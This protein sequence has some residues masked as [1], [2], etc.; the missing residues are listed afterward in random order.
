[1]S[2]I[3]FSFGSWRELRYNLG[4]AS[5]DRSSTRPAWRG[6]SSDPAGKGVAPHPQPGELPRGQVTVTPAW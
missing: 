6:T 1:M 4:I 3:L 5:T 2:H